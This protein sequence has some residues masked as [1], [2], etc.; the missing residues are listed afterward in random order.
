VRL[1]ART[2]HGLAL[3][4]ELARAGG[5]PLRLSALAARTGAPPA[6]LAKLVAPLKAAGLVAAARGAAGGIALAAPA[7]SLSVLRAVE[8][9]EGSL[10]EL[11]PALAGG[12]PGFG[13]PRSDP[14]REFVRAGLEAAARGFL[15]G[16]SVADL[17]AL[18]PGHDYAI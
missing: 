6:Y 4:V 16:S 14:V 13:S 11:D 7:S 2:V 3:L 1:S 18:G 5:P 12:S 10:V 9:L 15:S 8:A 17:A